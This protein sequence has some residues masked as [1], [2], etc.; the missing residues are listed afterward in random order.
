M[1]RTPTATVS[2]KPFAGI[3][4]IALAVA[5]TGTA[6]AQSTQKHLTLTS[7]SSATVAPHGMGFVGLSY[8]T[9]R[10]AN[11]TNSD[12]SAVVGIGVGSAEDSIGLQ[13]TANITSLTDDFADS[14][15]LS[16][17][18]SRQIAAGRNPTYASLEIG[19]LANWGD[20]DGIRETAT[21]AVTRF[22]QWNLGASQEQYPVMMTI[23]AGTNLRNSNS[24]PGVFAGIGIGLSEYTAASVAWAG[25]SVSIG[26]GFKIKG[27]D[28]LV[29]SLSLDDA[30]DQVDRQRLTLSVGYRFSNLFGG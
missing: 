6:N 8:T 13:F 11:V 4:A 27:A 18:A 22:S 20:A 30:F 2:R 14:G 1:R 10:A 16:V 7:I 29:I 24:D 5:L 12:G 21:I 25:E 28:N 15:F 9:N 3:A 26:G 17:K 19:Q 23:G